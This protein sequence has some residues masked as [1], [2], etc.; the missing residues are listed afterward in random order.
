MDISL[1]TDVRCADGDGG[2]CKGVVIDP[3]ARRITHLVIIE[4]GLLDSMPRLVPIEWVMES[5][6]HLIRL[7]CT[8]AE[9][10]QREPF[11][12]IEYIPGGMP[13]SP[14]TMPETVMPF[15]E[16]ERIPPGE[17]AMHRGAWVEAADGHVGQVDEFLVDPADGR[18]THLVLR[19]GHL[20]GQKE[21]IIPAAQIDWVEADVIHLKLDKHALE[22]L[23]T[24]PT[25]H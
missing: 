9:L 16:H 12:E 19:E 25:R 1:N 21:V 4:K 10:V 13:Y 20:W 22:K 24:V 14:Y 6:P 11:V 8:K 18:I 15:V 2:W 23:P 7:R 17:L 5:R 3:V